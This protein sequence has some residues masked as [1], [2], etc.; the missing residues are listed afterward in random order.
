M[1]GRSTVAGYLAARFPD[2][3]ARLAGKIAGGEVVDADGTPVT[4]RTPFTPGLEVFF[5]RDPPPEAPVPFALRVLHRDEH[6]LVVDKPHFLATMPRG[7]HITETALVRLRRSTGNDGLAPAHRLDRLTAGVL[8]F[9]THPAARRAYQDLFAAGGVRK[10]YEAVSYTAADAPLPTVVRSRIVKERGVHRA[11]ESQG[12]VNAETA[13]ERVPGGPHVRL[14][15]RPVTG[16]THQ[17]RVHLSSLGAPIAWDPLYGSA[18]AGPPT[19][20]PPARTSGGFD[21]P[22]QLLA[23]SLEFT[24]PFTGAPRRFVSGRTL[25]LW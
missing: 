9:T 4:E 14:R 21:R 11:Y 7:R 15:V 5:Y 2:D 10:T 23:R 25:D 17:I 1:P 6:L 3:A 13:V 18:S 24:D 19:S 16:K 20:G 8:V 22:L 12:A